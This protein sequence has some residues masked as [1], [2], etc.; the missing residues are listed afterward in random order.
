MPSFTGLLSAKGRSSSRDKDKA[1]SSKSVVKAAAPPA[2]A[3]NAPS[4]AE[5]PSA[6]EVAADGPKSVRGRALEQH[7][8]AWIKRGGRVPNGGYSP[9]QHALIKRFRSEAFTG[10]DAAAKA[11]WD[12]DQ[13]ACRFL[14][15]R[16]WDF[17]KGLLMFRNHLEWRARWDLDEIVQ[18][19][20]GPAPK[21][22]VDLRIPEIAALK[23]AVS[24]S[25][26][27]VS[28][29]GNPLYFDRIGRMDLAKLKQS[30]K[31]ETL[32]RYWVWYQEATSVVRLP[33]ASLQAGELITTSVYVLD[34]S[35]FHMGM[36][37]AELRHLL[38]ELSAI[39]ADN[40]PESMECTFIVNAPFSFRAVWNFV[41]P[42]LDKRVSDSFAIL[43]GPKEFVPRLVPK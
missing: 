29:A 3:A 17:D 9:A 25:H 1:G 22:L 18:T 26:H 23:A 13:T 33:A 4:A 39:S 21:L 7:L 15:A 2:A 36:F 38:K 5:A 11:W 35:G 24:F 14:E 32:V 12:N 19:S 16:H 8:D 34:L 37:N 43:G 30:S 42:L 20:A 10:L 40:Y 28:P 41:K 31:I 27:G 6:V